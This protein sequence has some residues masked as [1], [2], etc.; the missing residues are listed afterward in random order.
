MIVAPRLSPTNL[1]IDLLCI[2]GQKLN[3]TLID[4]ALSSGRDP[5]SSS[6][7]HFGLNDICYKYAVIR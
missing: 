2:A 1:R 3:I 7:N 5:T 6:N 4:F